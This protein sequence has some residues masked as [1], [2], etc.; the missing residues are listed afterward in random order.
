MEKRSATQDMNDVVLR[1]YV[2]HKFKANKATL[3]NVSTRD[4]SRPGT[5]G[6][7]KR[8]THAADYP[9]VVFFGE[10]ADKV[11][12]SVKEGDFV[13]VTGNMQ[14]SKRDV[15]T[16]SVFGEDI[17]FTESL[18]ESAAGVDAGKSYP[19]DKN[20]LILK[21]EVTSVK[22]FSPHT[23]G[24]IV[25]TVKNGHV[26]FVRVTYHVAN[27]DKEAEKIPNRSHVACVCRITTSKK[28]K[29]GKTNHYENVIVKELTVLE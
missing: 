2:V 28:E 18:L 20:E 4:Y 14:S 25:R 21:G 26:S 27:A 17:Q 5:V 10:L 12:N 9:E 8:I 24:L 11:A 15:V 19:E 29:D 3:I 22:V 6:E 16:Q 13:T 23:L 1:G 7:N